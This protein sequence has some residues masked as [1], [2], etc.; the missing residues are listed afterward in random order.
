[1]GASNATMAPIVPKVMPVILTTDEERDFW[2]R[3]Q[4]DAER[5]GR[6]IW[7]GSYVISCVLGRAAGP[8][9]VRTILVSIPEVMS[10]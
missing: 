2:M 6:G 3:A 9:T 4:R 5:A 7:A 8:P 1:M 10:G